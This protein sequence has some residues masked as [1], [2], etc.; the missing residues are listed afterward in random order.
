MAI[1]MEQYSTVHTHTHTVYRLHVS[2]V[3]AVLGEVHYRGWTHSRCYK[4][5]CERAN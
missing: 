1:V 3:A 2:A 5:L 4:V